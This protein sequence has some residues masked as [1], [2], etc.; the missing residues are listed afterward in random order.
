MTRTFLAY[1]L[2]CGLGVLSLGVLGGCERDK[3]YVNVVF[4]R[5]DLATDQQGLSPVADS[6]LVDPTGLQISP[7]GSFWVANAATATV[8]VYGFDGTPLP[9][10]EPLVVNL[11]V[12]ATLPPGTLPRATGAAYFGGYGL[13]IVSGTARDSAR[14]LFA[15]REGTILGYNP[16]IDRD[17]A[18]IAVDNSATGAVYRGL[19][20]VALRSGARL[21]ATNFHSG[22]VDVFDENF[23]PATG[24]DPAAF[25]DL[26]LPAGFAP[27]GIQRVDDRL[28]VSFAQQDAAGVDPVSGPGKGYIDSFSLNGRFLARVATEGDLDTPYGMALAPWSL[29]YF[30]GALF[31][32]NTGDGRINAYDLYYNT[33]IGGLHDEQNQTLFIDGLKDLSIGYGIE[34]EPAIYFTAGPNGGANGTFGTLLTRFIDVDPPHD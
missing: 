31:V 7:N 29:P 25:E 4:E 18:I 27:F 28:Y 8:T 6:H 9:V 34:G 1:I 2:R 11:P 21:Y 24:L 23:A 14:F 12:P 5:V 33:S 3:R 32:A 15:T 17:N 30:G 20:A 22:S 26:E 10:A 16:V 13:E 19:S